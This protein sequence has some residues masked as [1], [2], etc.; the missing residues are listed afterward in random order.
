MK[1]RFDIGNHTQVVELVAAV[2]KSA[3]SKSE[4]KGE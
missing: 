1:K 2:L 3:I 4:K